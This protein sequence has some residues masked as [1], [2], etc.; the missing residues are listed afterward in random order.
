MALSAYK[1]YQ[2]LKTMQTQISWLLMKVSKGAKIR[3][4]FRIHNVF[5]TN[6]ESIHGDSWWKMII[7]NRCSAFNL[8]WTGKRQDMSYIWQ[9]QCYK[10]SALKPSFPNMIGYRSANE[11]TVQRLKFVSKHWLDGLAWM[12]VVGSD[13]PAQMCRLIRAVKVRAF[14]SNF[15]LCHLSYLS[16]LPCKLTAG[17]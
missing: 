2:F 5:H 1:L 4:L 17:M 3:N 9:V 6:R 13:Q 14:L 11:A 7:F 12:D 16:G 15:Y 10:S 8:F